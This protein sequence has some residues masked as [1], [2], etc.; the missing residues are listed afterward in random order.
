MKEFETSEEYYKCIGDKVVEVIEICDANQQ[1]LDSQLLAQTMLV[2]TSC[3]QKM[4]AD[5]A[6]IQ[7][8]FILERF[9]DIFKGG[10]ATAEE[11]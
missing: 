5:F 11:E 3:N 7:Q 9:G 6:K 4:M 2:L 8:E 1:H 10:S